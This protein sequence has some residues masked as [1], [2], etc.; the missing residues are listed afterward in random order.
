MID[1]LGKK[2]V[3]ILLNKFGSIRSLIEADKDD[4]AKIEGIG[5]S[6]AEKIF[7]HLHL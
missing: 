1:G 6:L 3:N 4:I 2:R 7:Y 5:E